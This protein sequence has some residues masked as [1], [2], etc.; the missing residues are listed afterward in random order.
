MVAVPLNGF[1]SRESG[2]DGAT[3]LRW[4]VG[5]DEG[6][7][8]AL[9]GGRGSVRQTATVRSDT[10]ALPGGRGSAGLFGNARK[11]ATERRP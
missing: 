8:R 1:E 7:R 2:R 11:G 4:A 10:H 3:P 9:P 6:V 5:L